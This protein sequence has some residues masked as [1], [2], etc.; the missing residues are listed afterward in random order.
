MRTLDKLVI[1]RAILKDIKEN[2]VL[3]CEIHGFCDSSLKTCS[4][5]VCLK[6]FIKTVDKEWK[7]WVENRTNVIHA[8]TK[9]DLWIFVC[10]ECNSSDIG[11]RK[12]DLVGLGSNVLGWN[13]LS[14][15]M[16]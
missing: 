14:K 1:P 16:G 2:E 6:V 13:G 12:G 3:R 4:G 10:G 7:A 11:T 9:I 5:M 8:L 15:T